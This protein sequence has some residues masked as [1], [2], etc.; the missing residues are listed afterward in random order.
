MRIRL[1]TRSIMALTCL[2]AILLVLPGEMRNRRER[3][4][5]A[6]LEVYHRDHAAIHEQLRASCVASVGRVPYDA[7]MREWALM[8]DA[9][10]YHKPDCKDW[11]AE[12]D[13]H[14]RIIKDCL[15]G[16][17]S[18]ERLEKSVRRR[19]ILPVLLGDVPRDGPR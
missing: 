8:K 17:A 9:S 15:E 3:R 16:A 13:W 12:A 1:K 10:C 19:L 18:N 4:H 14:A 5:L 2:T 6:R 7:I 11:D